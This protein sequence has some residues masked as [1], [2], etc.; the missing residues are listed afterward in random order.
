MIVAPNEI[1]Y[2]THNK[3][4]FKC[5]KYKEHKSELKNINS[6][7]SGQEGS[8][9]CNQCNSI[10]QYILDNFPNKD[11][12]HLVLFLPGFYGQTIHRI[13]LLMSF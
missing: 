11:L 13:L 12:F 5:N 6:F 1:N 7:T 9:Q 8:I 2:G 10:A 3:Y 4:Y